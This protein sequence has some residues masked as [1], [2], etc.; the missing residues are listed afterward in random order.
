MSHALRA[1]RAG[2]RA[3]AVAGAFCAVGV[4]ATASAAIKEPLKL[5]SGLLGGSVEFAPGVR[6]FKGI[7]FAA[8]P[9]GALRWQAPQ[10]VAK[11]SGVRD[12]SKYGNVCIQPPGPSSGPQARLNI[13]NMEGSPPPSEDCLYLNVWTGAASATEKRPVMIW[14][15]GGAFTEGGGS[16]P[17]YDGTALAKKGVVVVTMN[18]RLG[19]YGFFVHPA[20]TAESPHKASGNYGLMDMLASARW[21]K[22]NIAAFG[23]DPDNVT[24][25]GQS[26]GAMAIA[27]LVASPESKGLFKRAISQSGAWMGLGLA[28]PMR[29]RAQ[30]EEAG[31]KAAT[32][33]GVKTAAEL[34]AMSAAEVT[35]KFRSAGM[36]VDGWVIPE[37]PTAVFASG[38]QNAVD[39]LVGSNKE[40]LSFGPP[41][42]AE[43]FVAGAKMRW[44]E[45]ADEYLKLYPHATDA[46]AA[47]AQIE[48]SSDGVFWL[49]RQYADY[50]AKKGNKAYLYFFT[51]NPPAPDGQPA[52]PAAHAAEVPYVFNNLG[53]LPLFPDRSVA[54]ISG[55]SAPDKKLADEM[56]SYWTN[57]AKT[58]DPNGPGL[59]TWK[60]HRPGKSD[61]AA[62]LD[63]DPASEKLPDPARVAFVDRAFERQQHAAH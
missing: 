29:T 12:A 50:Q 4:S 42:T 56:S 43:R 51:Q 9:V 5:D 58:G 55:K 7:P 3:L 63:A 49:M 53:Q 45:F 22:N 52:F 48:S 10:P 33:A 1:G 39:V 40:E 38:R 8:P 41:S 14:W 37:D 61:E 57:F 30:T 19:P 47:R 23:G 13:A 25:F 11:W 54:E 60:A 59:P 24:V 6:A 31:L 20:L 26:A 36:I 32:D 28:G 46:E 27:S 34:R 35:A 16:V 44:G 15:F 62:I 17:L 18:Y 2:V 21:V